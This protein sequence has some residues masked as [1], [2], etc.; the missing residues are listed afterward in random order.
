MASSCFLPF[1]LYPRPCLLSLSVSVSASSSGDLLLGSEVTLKCQVT[2]LNPDSTVQWESPGGKSHAGSQ[3]ELKSVA[4]SDAGT[5]KCTFSYDGTTYSE[6]LEIKVQGRTLLLKSLQMKHNKS[7]LCGHWQKQ[8]VLCFCFQNRKQLHRPLPKGQRTTV[9]Q[10]ALT[11]R[12]AC[13]CLGKPSV[14]TLTKVILHWMC[15]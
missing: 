9:N 15:H 6:S 2:G 12:T 4:R 10:A 13:V 5:W 1:S 14:S 7:Y 8:D 11:V 3:A